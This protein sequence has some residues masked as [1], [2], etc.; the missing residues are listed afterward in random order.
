MENFK[1]EI[2]EATK[3]RKI[4]EYRFEY[5]FFTAKKYHQVDNVYS[6]RD[7]IDWEEI[8]ADALRNIGEQRDVFKFE[9][10]MELK[11]AWSGW[12]TFKDGS[13]WLECR[14]ARFDDFLFI[15]RPILKK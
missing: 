6:G 1:K 5:Y 10:N 13:D 3:G 11:N 15:S 7:K 2:I 8:E 4:D 14:I 9:N 12:I